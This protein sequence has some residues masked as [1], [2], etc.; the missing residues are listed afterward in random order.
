MSDLGG[1]SSAVQNPLKTPRFGC[2]MWPKGDSPP[3]FGLNAPFVITRIILILASSRTSSLCSDVQ[4]CP[5]PKQDRQHN[6]K[7]LLLVTFL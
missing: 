3:T 6:L 7:W 2:I 4:I 1:S 5:V